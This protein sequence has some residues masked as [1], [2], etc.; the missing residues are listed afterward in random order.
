MS[1]VLEPLVHK[2]LLKIFDTK[3]MDIIKYFIFKALLSQPEL[4]IGR[5]ILP[6]HVPKEHIEQW[7]TQALTLRSIGAGSYPI[8]VY[9][10]DYSWGA[11]IKMLSIS[12]NSDG[13]VAPGESGETSLGQKFTG[14][15]KELDSMFS[16]KQYEKIRFYYSPYC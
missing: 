11:D 5:K 13:T 16:N 6:I 12:I 14:I 3:S 10:S 4:L 9:K 7:L 8:D 2:D 1:V 15:G